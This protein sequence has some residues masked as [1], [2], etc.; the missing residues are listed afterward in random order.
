MTCP[1]CGSERVYP[2]R[3]R[4]TIERLRHRLTDRQPYRCHDCGWR[5]WQQMA[6]TAPNP[7]VTPDDL[8]VGRRPAPVVA[9]DLDPLDPRDREIPVVSEQD[10]DPLDPTPGG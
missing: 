1:S 5:R 8:R 10:L 9:D 3:L 4:N 7:D 2:S 6:F